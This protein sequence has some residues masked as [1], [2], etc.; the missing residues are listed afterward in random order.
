MLRKSNIENSSFLFVLSSDLYINLNLFFFVIYPISFL[1][2]IFCNINDTLLSDWLSGEVFLYVLLNNF[3]F[4]T[5]SPF[6]TVQNS[7]YHMIT[8]WA[9]EMNTP[10]SVN[11]KSLQDWIPFAVGMLPVS[12]NRSMNG[13]PEPQL[14]SHYI[15]HL[16]VMY[17]LECKSVLFFIIILCCVVSIIF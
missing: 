10:L 14:S 8:T 13:E 16:C 17:F 4:T 2:C 5:H 3:I 1:M 12:K 6:Q 7:P 9:L 15:F 11:I